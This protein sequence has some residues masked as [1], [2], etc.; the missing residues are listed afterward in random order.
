MLLEYDT[1]DIIAAIES[2]ELSS[3]QLEG[4]GRLFSGNTFRRER[5]NGL[6]K[7]PRYMKQMLRDHVKSTGDED[8]M[9][10]A[11][12]AFMK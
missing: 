3:A 5:P 12:S 4:A 1:E 2:T 11:K 6:K 8:N 7:M 10:W 9:K